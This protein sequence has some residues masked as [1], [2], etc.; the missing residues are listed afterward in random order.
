MN[1]MLQSIFCRAHA[2]NKEKY[3]DSKGIL[4]PRIKKKEDTLETNK[5]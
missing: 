4:F 3:E 1:Q 2:C 5:E